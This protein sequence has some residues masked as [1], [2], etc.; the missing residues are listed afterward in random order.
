MALHALLF[1]FFCTSLHIGSIDA[2]CAVGQYSTITCTEP[3]SWYTT[4]DSMVYCSWFL[5]DGLNG[6]KCR[7]FDVCNACVCACKQDSTCPAGSITHGTVEVCRPCLPGFRGD[8]WTCTL[9]GMGEV[10]TNPVS[11]VCVAAPV[12][13]CPVTRSLSC[14][15]ICDCSPTTS[16]N[17][18]TIT[19]W[20]YPYRA[21]SNCIY[22]FT[23]SSTVSLKLT[24]FQ[25]E[26]N[27]DFFTIEICTTATCESSTRLLRASGTTTLGVYYSTDAARPFMRVTFTSD[28]SNEW[29]GFRGDWVIRPP[30][31][32]RCDAD[33]IVPNCL[34]GEYADSYQ[35]WKCPQ[36]SVSP[37]NSTALTSCVCNAGYSSVN[38]GI[39]T[40]CAVGKYRPR[41]SNISI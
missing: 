18:G 32:Q 29:D 13:K 15:G 30:I 33:F 1:L 4:P 8:G 19:D 5:S 37:E 12:S 35:C 28:G 20:Q 27:W 10:S 24:Q 23:S 17:T 3:Y 38:Q 31:L 41:P 40:A 6:G 11:D 2:I 39:C 36:N 25:T 7:L 22:I 16:A 21:D 14:S 26:N 34:V 9:C